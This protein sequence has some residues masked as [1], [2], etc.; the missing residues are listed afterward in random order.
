MAGENVVVFKGKKNGITILL[1]DKT[2][3]EQVKTIFGKKVIDAKKFFMGAEASISF[4]GRTLSEDEEAELLN[5]LTKESELKVSYVRKEEKPPTNIVED[6][7]SSISAKMKKPMEQQIGW[8]VMTSFHSGS[9]RS[10]QSIKYPGS[11]VVVGD[12]NPG[13]EVIAEGNVII[14]GTARGVVH[15]GCSGNTSC[16]VCALCLRP[17]QLRIA[18][19]ITH[20][21]YSFL[22]KNKENNSPSYAYIKND[23]LY[24]EPLI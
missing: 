24:I 13:A 2:E 9:L 14:L 22:E 16:Y 6:F 18:D 20:I 5:I 21:P 1:D 17:I 4:Q 7:I 3:F 15:A 8:E 12:I 23:K 11:V 10:G 19:M